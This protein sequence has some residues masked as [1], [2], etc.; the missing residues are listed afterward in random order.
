MSRRTFEFD[1]ITIH[2]WFSE[3]GIE[4]KVESNNYFGRGCIPYERNKNHNISTTFTSSEERLLRDVIINSQY[5]RH[6]TTHSIDEMI[7]T[8]LGNGKYA[9]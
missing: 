1:G 8:A 4:Y 2:T 5:G 6:C 7:G 9:Y 3:Y